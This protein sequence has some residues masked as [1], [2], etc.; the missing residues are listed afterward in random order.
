MRRFDIRI[1]LGAGLIVLGGLM[2]LEKMGVLRGAGS[3]F[4][5]AAFLVGAA[6]F[7][8]IFL[9]DPRGR[10]WMI[11]PGMVLLG[12]GGHAFLP[13]AFEGWDGALFLGAIGLAFWIVY[14]TDHSRWW[15][16]IPGGVLLT[17]AAVTVVNE[18]LSSIATGS[19]FLLGLALTFVL[20]ALL[21]NPV[22]KM[23]WAYIPAAVL[24][25]MGALLGSASTSGLVGYVWPA[26]LIVAGILTIFGFFFRRA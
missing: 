10:W 6:Y 2:L 1:I 26:A 15:G 8:Y 21:P 22:G 9:K 23:Q 4:W 17:L 13:A 19:V 11:I 14:L 24:A 7:F 16:I 3:L 18:N 20:V 12:I 5:G 25:V